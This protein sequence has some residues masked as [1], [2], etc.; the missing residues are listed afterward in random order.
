[1]KS[2]DFDIY[3]IF[4]CSYK[5]GKAAICF[6]QKNQFQKGYLVYDSDENIDEKISI[7]FALF[8]PLCL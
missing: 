8:N 5:D 1:M 6:E 2:N 7:I 4:F 3:F